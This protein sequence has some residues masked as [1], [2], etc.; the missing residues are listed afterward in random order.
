MTDPQEQRPD[1]APSKGIID[2]VSGWTL[3]DGGSEDT[4]WH[5]PEGT[6]P[7]T[8]WS[9]NIDGGGF[10]VVGDANGD[11]RTYVPLALVEHLARKHREYFGPE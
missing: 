2:N 5:S 10:L 8:C 1:H 4:V 6:E 3:E 9:E 7:A 11:A